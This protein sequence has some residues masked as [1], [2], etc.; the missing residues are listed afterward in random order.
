MELVVD[1]MSRTLNKPV[2]L[3]TRG[4]HS[5]VEKSKREKI[6][7]ALVHVIRNAVDHGIEVVFTC[8]TS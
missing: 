1:E 3:I 7:S 8:Q 6:S 4:S 2:K 5:L